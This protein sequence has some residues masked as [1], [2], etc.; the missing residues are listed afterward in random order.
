MGCLFCYFIIF[1]RKYLWQN[2]EIWYIKYLFWKNKRLV[3]ELRTKFFSWKPLLSLVTAVSIE[4][5]NV[6]SQVTDT[7]RCPLICPTAFCVPVVLRILYATLILRR[8]SSGVRG[9]SCRYT[10][11]LMWPHSRKS[12]GVKPGAMG[13]HHLPF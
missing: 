13:G 9:G 5:F 3:V 4:V 10:S 11:A 2:N 12:S 1:K 6:M 7:S 8:S